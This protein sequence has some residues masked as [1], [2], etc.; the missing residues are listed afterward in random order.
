MSDAAGPRPL[1]WIS[2]R[3]RE[4]VAA[5]P[6]HPALEGEGRVLSF[7]ELDRRVRV[8]AEAMSEG[9]PDPATPVAAVLG[10]RVDAVL[11]AYAGW[12]SGRPFSQIH[13]DSPPLR[14]RELLELIGAQ[15]V[16]ADAEHRHEVAR[17][18]AAWIDPSGLRDQPAGLD[19]H[20]AADGDDGT[21]T[22]TSGSTGRPK[23]VVSTVGSNGT[24]TQ[25][26]HAVYGFRPD[27]RVGLTLAPSFGAATFVFPTP[28]FGGTLCLFDP[29]R[30]GVDGLVQWLHD[31]HITFLV[32][33]PVLLREVLGRLAPGPNLPHLRLV[34]PM[35]DKVLGDDVH[36]ARERLGPAVRIT[37]QFGATEV[38]PATV[39]DYGPDTPVPDGILPVGVP[40][41]G[42]DVWI[43]DP[44]DRGVGPIVI[45]SPGLFDRYWKDPALTASVRR[46]DPER[47]EGH[48]LVTGDIGKILP[49]GHL[50]FMGRHDAM[51]KIRGQSVDLS[52]IE[53]HL[54]A[55]PEVLEALV[56]V[57]EPRADAPR[58][59]AHVVPSPDLADRAR[60]TVSSIRAALGR[61][62]PPAMLPGAVV[63]CDHFP[64]NDRGKVERDRLPPV[65]PGRPDLG[66]AHRP[67][68]GTET[69]VAAAFG[70][71]LEIDG[72]GGDDDFFELGGDSLAVVEVVDRLSAVLG[73]GVPYQAM[74]DPTVAA[75][76]RRCDALLAGDRPSPVVTLTSSGD[77]APLFLVHG[78]GGLAE[79]LH[80][81]AD[82]L[83]GSRPVHGIEPVGDEGIALL[84]SVPRTAAAYVAA[85][86]SVHPEGP[87]VVGGHSGGGVIAVEMA[88]QLEQ[89]GRQ[90]Q[91]VLLLDTVS[92]GLQL[93]LRHDGRVDRRAVRRWAAGTRRWVVREALLAA[94][95]VPVLSRAVPERR[96]S[97]ERERAALVALRSGDPLPAEDR[98]A[99][100]EAMMLR[101]AR[102]WRPKRY[103]GRAILVRT[104]RPRLTAGWVQVLDDL[105]VVDVDGDHES[106][107]RPPHVVAL[108]E[109][110]DALLDT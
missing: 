82:A 28:V 105:T 37:G 65:P 22:F 64:R 26:L 2:A 31:E 73:V 70:A 5:H 14:I 75:V 15:A 60:P 81:L 36:L 106:F 103:G 71:V 42:V 104:D 1:P 93:P 38:G 108:A 89:R 13:P 45:R 62:L 24:R 41:P 7:A 86:E 3:W 9:S 110:L 46:P 32:V 47:P 48:V 100:L 10:S 43:D 67:P 8:L 33:T 98:R 56:S 109:R 61:A 11:A 63:V 80:D 20:V 50:V 25:A 79:T 96:G 27:D 88:R 4:A 72:V 68:E 34:A 57:D 35:A 107:V 16:V 54:T 101:G 83:A 23:G 39:F 94:W 92:V 66:V 44:D 19:L 52:E 95:D 53:R 76:A 77:G 85:I 84:G 12:M 69:V 55:L 102:R 74:A 40:F 49:N 97:P 29:A 30:S 91:S 90:P 59:V 58:I 78:S 17:L 21:L 18:G 6:E 99:H 87:L 51:A